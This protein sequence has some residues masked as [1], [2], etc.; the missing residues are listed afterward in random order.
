MKFLADENIGF[1]I[2]KSLRKR[3]YNVKSI[4]DIQLGLK[5]SE[6]LL[7]ANKEKRILITTDKNFGEL[8][9][10]NKLVHTGVILLRL[11]KETTTEK[12]RVLTSLFEKQLKLDGKFTVVTENKIRIRKR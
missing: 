5:D 12:L 11:K 4:R 1:G 10:V 7:I 8:V 3:G 9:F 6:V 2:I